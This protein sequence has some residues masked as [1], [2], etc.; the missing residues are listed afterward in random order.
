M[1]AT[2]KPPVTYILPTIAWASLLE[3]IAKDAPLGAAIEVHTAEMQ[4]VTEEAVQRLERTDILVRFRPPKRSGDGGRPG[5]PFFPTRG[6]A[7]CEPE[8]VKMRGSSPLGRARFVPP[9][10]SYEAV[11]YDK[12]IVASCSIPFRS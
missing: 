1:P 10:P 3:I 2:E 11:F 6:V 12:F 5:E 4:R 8:T 7:R 9:E